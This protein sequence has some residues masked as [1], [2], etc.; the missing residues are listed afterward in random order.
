LTWAVTITTL[1]V[2]V[3]Y[4]ISIP[5]SLLHVLQVIVNGTTS[6][7]HTGFGIRGA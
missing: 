6:D 5:R 1:F 3:I 7:T 2:M 4:T